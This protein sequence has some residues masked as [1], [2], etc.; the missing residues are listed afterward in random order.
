DFY[1]YL[2]LGD[3][4]DSVGR[5][6]GTSY[7]QE[8]KSIAIQAKSLFSY[9]VKGWDDRQLKADA[10]LDP[11]YLDYR[12][13]R[14][15]FFEAEYQFEQ[16]LPGKAED[17]TRKVVDMLPELLS[18]TETAYHTERFLQVR[19]LDLCKFLANA[20]DRSVF[21]RLAELDPKN[22]DTY[23]RFQEGKL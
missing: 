3:E 17:L 16:G 15:R 4:L 1:I 6:L 19:Y 14:D 8:A 23:R 11:R 5:L 21:D 12:L 7:F 10:F 18:K 20:K 13:M 22:K 9:N 2:M